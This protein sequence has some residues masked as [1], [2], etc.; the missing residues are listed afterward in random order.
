[1]GLTC[2][3]AGAKCDPLQNH[4]PWVWL[5]GELQIRQRF[6]SMG[7]SWFNLSC[8]CVKSICSWAG[9]WCLRSGSVPASHMLEQC[10][11]FR[12]IK[13]LSYQVQATE[14]SR[15]LWLW[16]AIASLSRKVVWSSVSEPGLWSKNVFQWS[17]NCT[18][19]LMSRGIQPPHM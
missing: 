17:S 6:W 4:A 15:L 16:E 3:L 14:M 19:P 18:V 1:M 12:Y 13:T 10:K 5:G 8:P 11:G 9:V 7:H 2:C